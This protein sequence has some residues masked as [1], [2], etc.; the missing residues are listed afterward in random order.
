MIKYASWIL[1][2][3]IVES[4]IVGKLLLSL[5]RLKSGLESRERRGREGAA[6]RGPR[7][8][9]RGIERGGR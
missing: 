8:G 7:G 1:N 3:I 9:D 2:E 6:G 4:R 5:M